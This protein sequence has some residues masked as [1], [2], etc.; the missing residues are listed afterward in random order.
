[1]IDT[2]LQNVSEQNRLL[3]QRLKLSIDLGL[4]RQIFLAVCD[5][6]WLR[7]CLAT[8]LAKDLAHRYENSPAS[9]YPETGSERPQYPGFV[10]LTLNLSDPNPMA[11]I[12]DWLSQNPGNGGNP[13]DAPPPRNGS[14]VL[15]GFQIL[16]VERL[17]RQSAAVQRLF[18]SYLQG[19]E[20]TLLELETTFVMWMPRPWMHSIRQSAP[21]FWR[22]RT[23]VFEFEGEPTPTLVSAP[24]RAVASHRVEQQAQAGDRNS[25]V[26]VV[27]R[28]VDRVSDARPAQSPPP[29]TEPPAKKMP[30]SREEIWEILK[31]DLAKFGN[32]ESDL[33]P[34]PDAP[35]VFNKAAVPV[36]PVVDTSAEPTALDHAPLEKSPPHSQ[37]PN[38]VEL[39]KAELDAIALQ[40]ANSTVD[41]V[42][43]QV[44]VPAPVETPPLAEPFT[45]ALVP[46][47]ASADSLAIADS[48]APIEPPLEPATPLT[49][50]A[51]PQI[52]EVKPQS[53]EAREYQLLR[54]I[55]QLQLQQADKSALALAYQQLGNVYRDRIEQGDSAQLTLMAAIQA[56]EQ[57]IEYLEFQPFV[58][59]AVNGERLQALPLD[60]SA[61]FWPDLLNDLGNLYWM[62]S[63]CPP[64]PKEALIYLQKGIQTYHVALQQIDPTTQTQSYALVQNNLGAAYG[65]LARYQA[66]VESLQNSVT[67]YRAALQYRN[68]EVEPLKYAATQNNIG[69]TYWNLAQHS[70]P[71]ENLKCAIAAYTEALCYCS[72]QQEPMSYAMIQNNLGTAYWN[73][74]QY[75][76]SEAYLRLA[77]DA[78]HIALKYR[79][80]DAAPTACA[81]TNNNLGTAYWHLANQSQDNATLRQEAL[82]QAIDAYD[83][84]LK[85][86]EANRKAGQKPLSFDLLATHNNLGLAY[87]QKATDARIT[88]NPTEQALFLEKALHH[89]LT[90]LDGWQDRSEL[91]QSA[92][93]YVVQAVQAFHDEYGLQGQNQAM[94]SIPGH[95]LPEVMRRL[96]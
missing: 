45:T 93:G 65:D 90:A 60:L 86:V 66:P 30:A 29:A 53:S 64:H 24:R 43:T 94:S 76:P 56:Y 51:L 52:Q 49:P 22:W 79:T 39:D 63:H 71:V 75:E 2:T 83:Q 72:L 67:A 17:T 95:L 70:Q 32:L 48:A 35:P 4:R 20:R 37:P 14:R 57:T 41:V 12:V 46:A 26:A 38:T 96:R 1:M 68:P 9:A 23:G 58:A 54:Y 34:L 44:L 62:L 10:S 81:A 25:N 6:L 19:V 91:Y 8:R 92:L 84:T 59:P 40:D 55:E 85:L 78:Y 21:E 89:H 47:D 80:A 28:P 27:E 18:L 74:S 36:D 69:T 50:T 11:Q 77:I 15:P 7:D 82:T 33:F 5:D 61:N 42:E 16:G 87:Y 3:Y 13:G 31:Q 73:L 88:R